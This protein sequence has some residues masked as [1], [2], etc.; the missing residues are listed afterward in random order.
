VI[1]PAMLMSANVPLPKQVFGHGWMSVNGQRMSKS[2]GNVVDPLDAAAHAGVDPLRLY[3]VKEVPYGGDG[4]FS[5]ERL[6]EKYNADLANNLGNLVSR[7]AAMTERYRG[8]SLPAARSSDRLAALTDGAVA[9]Y[10]RAMDAYLLHEGVAAAFRIVDAANLFI[11]DTQPWALAKEPAQADR[12]TTVLA[13]AAE[14]VRIA[15]ILLLPV[16][17]VS[18][19]EILRRIGETRK[20]SDLRIVDHAQWRRSEKRILNE[21]ALWPRLESQSGGAVAS[22]SGG[23]STPPRSGG[24]SAPPENQTVTDDTPTPESPT[25]PLSQAAAPVAADE[26]ISIDDFMKVQLRVG[27]VLAAE[28]VPKSK[29]LLKLSVDIGTE[30][31]TLVAGIAEAYEPEAIVGKSVVIVANLQPAKLMGIESNGMVLA[32]SPEGGQP[33]VLDASS[34]APG[35]RVR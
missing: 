12:L 33:I 24:A 11:A 28:R 7:V 35:T 32:A 29:K 3:L 27:K 19:V 20:P 9:A 25:A 23:R 16:M 22:R 4:D 13:D 18:A 8:G 30:Q 6:S 1:W 34:A 31:R 2:L 10:R 21:G 15:A 26:R 17:P 14:A 5:Y